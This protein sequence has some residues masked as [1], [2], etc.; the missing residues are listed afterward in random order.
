MDIRLPKAGAVDAQPQVSTM[1]TV[2]VS[3]TVY[4]DSVRIAMPDLKK[5]LI[6]ALAFAPGMSVVI[7]A[8]KD[9]RYE[10]VISVADTVRSAGVTK[11]TLGVEKRKEAPSDR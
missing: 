6:D 4:L 3:G 8:D 1:I 5:K 9:T 10:T 11:L 7:L 2:D